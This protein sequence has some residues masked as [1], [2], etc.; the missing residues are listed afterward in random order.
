MGDSSGAA[1]MGSTR[2]GTPSLLWDMTGDSIDE[3]HTASD[4]EGRIDLPS[5]RRHGTGP[6][7]APATTILW[8]ETTP[9]A[10]AI[11]TILPRH[12]AS[13]HEPR[14]RAERILKIDYAPI[15]ALGKGESPT[16]SCEGG[17]AVTKALNTSPPPIANVV[18]KLYHQ[19]A[20][21]HTI[22][23]TQIAE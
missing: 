9:T 12:V 11:K 14:L 3:F 2:S 8:S 1:I 10:Q 6:S 19:L 4:G 20:E 21:I 16:A 17:Q 7:T 23:T 13:R 15:Q 22:A 18:D 5:P